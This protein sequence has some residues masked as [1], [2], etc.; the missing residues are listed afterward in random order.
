MEDWGDLGKIQIDKRD[1]DGEIYGDVERFRK[2]TG[3]ESGRS[4][5]HTWRSGEDPERS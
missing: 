3:E 5:G 1:P 4:G 2:D